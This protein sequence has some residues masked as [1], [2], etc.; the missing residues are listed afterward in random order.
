LPEAQR[1]ELKKSRST[2]ASPAGAFSS[3]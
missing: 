3:V 2:I 1:E